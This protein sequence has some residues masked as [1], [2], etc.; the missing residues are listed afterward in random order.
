[1]GMYT[2]TRSSRKHGIAQEH[3]IR[4]GIGYQDKF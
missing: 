4:L 1:M 3:R 2:R